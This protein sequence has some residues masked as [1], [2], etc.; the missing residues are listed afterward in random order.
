MRKNDVISSNVKKNK[1]DGKD[2]VINRRQLVDL[3]CDLLQ[4]KPSDPIK[5]YYPWH[6]R[7]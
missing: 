3:F 6:K 4:N 2:D 1:D 7:V 5:I